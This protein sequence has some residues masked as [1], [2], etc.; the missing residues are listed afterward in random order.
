M[1][2]NQYLY[3]FKYVCMT[4]QRLIFFSWKLDDFDYSIIN[5]TS[6]YS[7]SRDELHRFT[8]FNVCM[9]ERYWTVQ[10][11][12]KN[13]YMMT[14]TATRRFGACEAWPA[15]AAAVSHA[16][17]TPMTVA[18]HHSSYGY[19]RRRW[20]KCTHICAIIMLYY[21]DYYCC[22]RSGRLNSK[23]SLEILQAS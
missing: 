10:K 23:W 11:N 1:L 5:N 16:L 6:N 4:F 9:W 7:Q 3:I 14:T 21:Y 13:Y 22:A 8:R 2:F 12:V 17:P 20:S 19:A 18:G 15:A